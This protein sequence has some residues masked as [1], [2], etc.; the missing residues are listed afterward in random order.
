MKNSLKDI[1][2]YKNSF[3]LYNFEPNSLI[4]M[5][6]NFDILKYV[7]MEL[8][9]QQRNTSN[10][11]F[12]VKS[13]LLEH[14]KHSKEIESSIIEMQL[15][16]NLSPEIKQKLEEEKNNLIIKINEIENEIKSL[17]NTKTDTSKIINKDAHKSNNTIDTQKNDDH[18]NDLIVNNITAKEEILIENNKKEKN[19]TNIGNDHDKND[20]NVNNDI[21]NEKK[22]DK[23]E[24]DKQM[25]EDNKLKDNEI[26]DDKN[27]DKEK[28]SPKNDEIYKQIEIISAEIKN[29]KYQQ[30]NLEK[31]IIEY[32]NAT[33]D[34][35]SQKIDTSLPLIEEKINSK[36]EH[37]KKLLTE[38]ITKNTDNINSFQ[39][40][41]NNKI[42]EINQSISELSSKENIDNIAIE[43]L[44]KSNNSLLSKINTISEALSMYTKITDFRQYKNDI[45][46]K[47][48]SDKK[49]INVNLALT[50]KGLNTLKN[51]F[52]EYINDQTDHNNLEALL[53][54]FETVQSFIYKLQD[55]QREMEE[56]EKRRIVI[57]PNK[58]VKLDAFNEYQTNVHKNLDTNKKEFIEMRVNF[59]EFKAKEA[60]TKATLKDLK[61]LEDN[62]LLRM[63]DLKRIISDNFVDKITLNKN[64]KIIKMQTKQLIEDNKKK[65]KNENWL[66]AKRSLGG[67]LCASCEAYLGELSPNTNSKFIHWNKYP[68]K[69]SPDKLF[70]IGGGISKILQMVN[71]RNANNTPKNSINNNNNR[72][73]TSARNEKEENGINSP[74]ERNIIRSIN[75]KNFRNKNNINNIIKSDQDD[76]DYA[77]NLPLISATMRKNNSAMNVFNSDMNNKSTSTNSL[78]NFKNNLNSNDNRSNNR[79]ITKEDFYLNNEKKIELMEDDNNNLKGPK[80]TKVY[81]KH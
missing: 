79:N 34:G 48:N 11:I 17:K 49:E 58:Y 3:D 67:H 75:L 40:D 1:E 54:K 65:E 32:K 53:K 80:I 27:K 30:L 62:I 56:K 2:N 12:Q 5:S 22:E 52:F 37:I 77:N 33:D 24:S 72:Y 74:K 10:D 29:L 69:E 78:N 23:N 59:D 19:N 43:E 44:K 50:Q 15:S 14:K 6:F 18:K 45:L 64:T 63:E 41:F 38:N 31:N 16:S 28:K 47:I 42:T 68:A 25:K 55:F 35:I 46:E 4:A 60:G 36:I 70:K 9:N 73:C 39:Q 76:Y 8:I 13:E 26:K 20:N 71:S 51:Q 57:D 7:L 66:L 61:L 81:K 21:I